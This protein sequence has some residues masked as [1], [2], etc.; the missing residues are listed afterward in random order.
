[1]N[2]ASILVALNLS[3]LCLLYHL[4]TAGEPGT[5]ETSNTLVAVHDAKKF[6]ADLE[7]ELNRIE[8]MEQP[9]SEKE[10]GQLR[11]KQET[12]LEAEHVRL[13]E[14]NQLHMA[15]KFSSDKWT[16]SLY[17]KLLCLQEGKGALFF[18]H[19]RKAAGTTIREILEWKAK[20]WHVQYYETEGVLLNPDILSYDGIMS[21]LSLRDPVSRV[22][23]L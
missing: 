6:I 1:M 3:L 8:T 18:Y 12:S 9:D 17:R 11:A 22:L 5:A 23:S 16:E 7:Y 13:E 4:H 2:F 15:L 20:A 21:V 19:S 10:R 14:G